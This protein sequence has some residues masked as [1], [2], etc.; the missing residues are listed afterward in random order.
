MR[1]NNFIFDLDND[2]IGVARASCNSDHNQVFDEN[3]MIPQQRYV[4]DLNSMFPLVSNPS[5]TQD[6]NTHSSESSAERSR[7]ATELA[8]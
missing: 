2:L 7:Q 4:K 3:E 5:F 8:K 1:Q 6:C